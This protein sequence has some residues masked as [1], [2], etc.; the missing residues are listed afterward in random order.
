MTPP[1]DRDAWSV[2]GMPVDNVTRA[3]AAGLIE[4]AITQRTRLSF[5]TPNVNW[6][7]RALKDQNAMDQIIRADLSLADGAPI[8]W[9][10]RQLGMP[11]A[12]RVAGSD[13][14]SYLQNDTR[15]DTLPIR[16]FFFGGRDGAA[17]AACAQLKAE[18]GRL[19]P[20]GWHNPGYGRVSDMTRPDIQAKIN[21]TEPDFIVVALGAA[22]GQ[23]WIEANLKALDAPV[24]AHLGAVV[25]FVGGTIKQAP[26]FVSRLGLEW[27]WRIFA[28]PSLWRRYWR[29]GWALLGL[30]AKNLLPLRRAA[31]FSHDPE[32]LTLSQMADASGICLKYRGD[33]VASTRPQLAPVY[34]EISMLKQPV[35]LDLTEVGAIDAAALGQIH[36]LQHALLWQDQTLS[37]QAP[38]HLAAAIAAAGLI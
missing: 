6:L 31:R 34:A 32:P 35:R 17:E 25:D 15:T 23:A 18:N 11:I 16:V 4:T 38:P 3:E 22:K 28:E 19:I 13:L 2:M 26:A 30:V 10:A 21:A 29:D 14:F 5:V 24:I 12:E 1:F 33:L 37:L 8:V 20:V 7:V 36:L 27:V 9:L